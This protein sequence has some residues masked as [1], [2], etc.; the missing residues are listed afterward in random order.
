[1]KIKNNA[2]KFI[3]I[4]FWSCIIL[5]LFNLNVLYQIN[6]KLDKIEFN[7]KVYVTIKSA[8]HSEEQMI[9]VDFDFIK[10]IDES[11]KLDWKNYLFVFFDKQIND[12]RFN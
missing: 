9:K 12:I 1:M 6:N 8:P 10:E 11:I 7:G 4:L 2:I 5:Q 3:F